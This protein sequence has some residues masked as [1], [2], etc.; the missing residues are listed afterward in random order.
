MPIHF[1]NSHLTF[2]RLLG[3]VGVIFSVG[4]CS[5]LHVTHVPPGESVSVVLAKMPEVLKIPVAVQPP[6]GPPGTAGAAPAVE[7]D[8]PADNTVERVAEA[9]SR[10]EFCLGA[11]KDKEAMEAF[12]EAVKIDPTFSEAWQ[13][14][15]M[16]YEKKGD[17][18]K[19]L[20]AFR[21]AKKLARQ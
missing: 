5:Q 20:D 7:P 19:A 17:S 18:K 15:A 2:A 11:G 14:L 13:H 10:G 1:M 16:L 12:Q 8:L 9:Y 3:L 21:R 6:P 4:A